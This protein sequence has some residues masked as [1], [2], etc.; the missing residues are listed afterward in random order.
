MSYPPNDPQQPWQRGNSQSNQPQGNESQQPYGQQPEPPQQPY[1]QQ[2]Q[3][4]EPQQP[5][6]QPTSPQQPYQ[7]QPQQPYQQPTGPQQPYGQPQ[8]SPQAPQQPAATS[9]YPQTP[10]EQQPTGPQHPYTQQPA[11][12]AQQTQVYP[13]QNTEAYPAG[14]GGQPPQKKKKSMVGWIAGGSALLL[15]IIAGVV[16]FAIGNAAHAPENQV[17]AYLD[18]L[19][20]GKAEQALKDSGVKVEKG[21]VLLTD[22]A[23]KAADD[24]ISKYSISSTEISGDSAT[25]TASISQGGETY[26][27]DFSLSKAGKDMVFFD[28]WKLDAPKLGEVSYSVV[29]PQNAQVAVNGVTVAAESGESAALRALPGTYSI[30]MSEDQG[31]FQAEGVS[32]T[33]LGFGNEAEEAPELT[34]TLSEEG[35]TAAEEAVTAFLDEC[36]ASTEMAPDGC[37]NFASDRGTKKV[38]DIV[39]T[40]DPRPEFS[41]GE[42]DG[43][44]WAVTTDQMG[45]ADLSATVTWPND[46]VEKNV[47]LENPIDISVDGAV[48]FGED[49]TATFEWD[50]F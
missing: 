14:G 27:Q 34:V 18:L 35:V 43:S 13:P 39:W 21:D 41:V 40:I 20:A 16:G 49:G 5:Y 37:P 36:E 17:T 3:Q 33:V 10:G 9:P 7:Q 45:E 19:K 42:Y 8:Q 26:E 4:S 22:E 28:K 30:A 31:V 38:E 47:G 24:R 50:E 23:Y 25:V 29:G 46:T 44:G 1:G 12:G 11:Y 48:T 2:P 32:T 6:Q 15:I